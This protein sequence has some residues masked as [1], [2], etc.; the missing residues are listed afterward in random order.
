MGVNT[1]NLVRN[2]TNIN[3]LMIRLH[4][5]G[6]SRVLTYEELAD[7]AMRQEVKKWTNGKVCQARRTPSIAVLILGQTIKLGLNCVGGRDTTT[8]CG[9]LG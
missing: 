2:R 7:K 1:I 9:Y 5:L 8:M 6:A 3:E 4:A